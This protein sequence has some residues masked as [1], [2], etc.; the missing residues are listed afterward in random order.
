LDGLD[1]GETLGA[2]HGSSIVQSKQYSTLTM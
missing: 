1:G 2:G